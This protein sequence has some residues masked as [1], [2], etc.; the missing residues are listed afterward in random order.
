MNDSK[1]CKGCENDGKQDVEDSPCL[2]CFG[3][4]NFTLF[5]EGERDG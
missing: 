5:G 1:V 4:M 2:G 3:G